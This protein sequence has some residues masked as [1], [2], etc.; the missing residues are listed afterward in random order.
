M[1]ITK[2][3]EQN[4]YKASPFFKGIDYIQ[5]NFIDKLVFFKKFF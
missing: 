2:Y 5:T 1:Y 3:K 4:N